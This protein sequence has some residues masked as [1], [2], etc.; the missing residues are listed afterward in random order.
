MADRLIRADFELL[1]ARARLE[2]ASQ[3][4]VATPPDRLRERKTSLEE[5]RRK[6]DLYA[7]YVEGAAIGRAREAGQAEA[8]L[9]NQDLQYLRRNLE[10]IRSKLAQL[11]FEIGQ[12]SFR[13]TVQDEASVPRVPARNRRYAAIA[14]LATVGLVM[15]AG[16]SWL[17]DLRSRRHAGGEKES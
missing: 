11:E 2:S 5:A 6:R 1:D 7:R 10:V 9:L 4:D 15:I 12:E 3:P 14:T 8:S 13:I 16:L 17:V